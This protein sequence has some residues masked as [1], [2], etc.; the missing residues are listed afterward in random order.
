MQTQCLSGYRGFESH[1]LRHFCKSL[2]SLPL[3]SWCLCWWLP[4]EAAGI[5]AELVA[6]RIYPGSLCLCGF[7]SRHRETA[8]SRAEVV[9]R[10]AL[11]PTFDDGVPE[12]HAEFMTYVQ[13]Y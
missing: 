10:A 11:S 8:S 2:I 6:M 3:N 4:C 1:P 13:M 12:R 7:W 5:K 9:E